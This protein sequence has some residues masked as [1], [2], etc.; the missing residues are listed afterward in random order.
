MHLFILLTTLLVINISNVKIPLQPERQGC[1][2]RFPI[3][4]DED[5]EMIFLIQKNEHNLDVLKKLLSNLSIQEKFDIIENDDF[6]PTYK[7]MHMN[8]GGLMNDWEFDF[9]F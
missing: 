2:E 5:K 6:T 3:E 4:Y 8:A 1:D 9:P 7:S